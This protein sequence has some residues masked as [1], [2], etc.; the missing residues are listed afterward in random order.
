QKAQVIIDNI[1]EYNINGG[2]G[3]IRINDFFYN[4]PT[5]ENIS[6]KLKGVIVDIGD[7]SVQIWI[8][9]GMNAKL[10]APAGQNKSHLWYQ[11]GQDFFRLNYGNGKLFIDTRY[12]NGDGLWDYIHGRT[13]VNENPIIKP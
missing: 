13:I 10:Y 7:A 11:S 5:G 2:E 4:V 1:R 12:I 6:I 9:G 3:D 8:E